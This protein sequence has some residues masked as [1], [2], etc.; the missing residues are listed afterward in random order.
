MKPLARKSLLTAHILVAVGWIGAVA[1]FLALSIVAIA[2][3][4]PEVIRGNYVAM[5]EVS[6]F[7]VIPFSFATLATG[8]FQALGSQWG[9]FKHYWIVTKFS[10]ATLATFALLMHQ[11]MAVSE[12]T[13]RVTGAAADVL[14]GPGLEPFKVELVRA[15]AI[16]IVVLMTAATLGVFKPWGLTPYGRRVQQEKLKMAQQP[17]SNMPTGLKIFMGVIASLLAVFVVLHLTGHGFNH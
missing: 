7:A 8:L 15:P 2:S 4:N 5:N 1:A 16:A 14:L 17:E 9:L 10:L 11:V 3:Q 12:T 6:R 13:R